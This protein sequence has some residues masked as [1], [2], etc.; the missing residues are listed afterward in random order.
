VSEVELRQVEATS[1]A[2][3]RFA[4]QAGLGFGLITVITAVTAI[5]TALFARDAAD[6]RERI[7]ETYADD[8]AQAFQAE[9]AAEKMVAIARGYLLA[10]EPELLDRLTETEGE[11]DHALGALDRP[12]LSSKERQL[13]TKVSGSAAQYREIFDEVLTTSSADDHAER[14]LLFRE[15]LVPRR[16][17]LGARLDELVAHKRRMQVEA[18]GAARQIAARTFALVVGLSAIAVIFSGLLAWRFITQ[19]AAIYR[20]E[21]ESA[22][23]AQRA[24]A[25][26]EEL[27]GI[28]AHDLRNPLGAIRMRAT[29][30]ERHDD[31]PKTRE[32]AAAIQRLTARM[33]ALISSLLEA[34]SIEAGR[35]SLAWTRCSVSE[36]FATV[37]EIFSAMAGAKNV[38]LEQDLSPPALT[39]RGDPER[40]SQVLSNLVGNALKFTGAGGVIRLRAVESGFHARFEVRDTGPGIAPQHLPRVFDRFWRAEESGRKGTGLGLYITKGIVEAHHGHIWVESRI[41]SGSA[42]IFELPIDQ[43]HAQPHAP[44]H[45][46][47]AEIDVTGDRR[48]QHPDRHEATDSS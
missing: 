28:V 41:G 2:R 4:A 37:T 5:G 14:I 18:R 23:S 9:L 29:S 46:L 26:R 3:P 34:A 8:L 38:A 42:F 21:Q 10:P 13:L 20:R 16:R 12:A 45:A 32:R 48:R 30:I 7:L 1:A 36:L 17:D 15:Q 44:T 31:D 39:I 11:L 33:D 24:S 19:L 47:T 40:L 22:A 25:A 27:L 35:L 6:K 43:P